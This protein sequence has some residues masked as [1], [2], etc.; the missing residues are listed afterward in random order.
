M[1]TAKCAF[2]W[3]AGTPAETYTQLISSVLC[4]E[5]EILRQPSGE[6]NVLPSS[7]TYPVYIEDYES[8]LEKVIHWWCG[9]KFSN[10]RKI[11][12]SPF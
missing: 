3:L 4:V 8:V 10:K 11:R 1:I 6:G 2:V 12:F 7:R 9:G 5:G